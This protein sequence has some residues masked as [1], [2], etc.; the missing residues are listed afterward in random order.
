MNI[1]KTFSNIDECLEFIENAS[2][3]KKTIFFITSSALSQEIIP[4]I[5]DNKYVYSIY[6]LFDFMSPLDVWVN[7]SFDIMQIIFFEHEL[8]LLTRLT[9]DIA[10]Y[11]EEK[12]SDDINPQEKL[13][14]LR[15]ARKLYVNAI[16]NDQ[17]R[18]PFETLQHF[19][20][21]IEEL[22]NSLKIDEED[23]DEEQSSVE[24]DES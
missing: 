5:L 16:A 1:F 22:E 23:N 13:S 6:I 20:Q 19:E 12:S 10:A 3:S 18:T 21:R 17:Q 11:Y 15:W 14:Y 4:S 24:C 8:D 9:R 7:Y 2:A